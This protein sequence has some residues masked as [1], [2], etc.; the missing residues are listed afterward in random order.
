M[1]EGRPA[2]VDRRAERRALADWTKEAWSGQFR[3]VTV[4]GDAGIGKTALVD[5]LVEEWLDAGADVRS[6]V[7]HEDLEIPYLPVVTAIRRH[8]DTRVAAADAPASLLDRTPDL[9]IAITDE[10]LTAAGHGRIVL[11]IDDLHWADPAT[12][13]LL[14]HVLIAASRESLSHAL[15][16]LVVLGTRPTE[17]ER[18]AASLLERLEREGANRPLRLG[19]LDELSVNEMLESMLTAPPSRRLLDEVLDITEGNP[20]FVR[21]MIEH[22][23]EVGSLE[24]RHDEVVPL[25]E[26]VAEQVELDGVL[27]RRVD[28]LSDDGR[29]MLSL[30]AHMGHGHD[31]DELR[32]V[33]GLDEDPFDDCMD[34]LEGAGLMIERADATYAFP[35][36]LVRQLLAR[37]Q[38]RRA[39]RGVHAHIAARLID[40]SS[41]PTSE[42]EMRIAHHLRRAARR[43]PL[44]QLLHFATRATDHCVDLGAWAKAARYAD[45][46]LGALD[47]AVRT[48]GGVPTPGDPGG[49]DA[50]RTRLHLAAA[51]AN[52]RNHDASET[53][54]HCDAAIDAARASDDLDSWGRALLI[55]QR[56]RLTLTGEHGADSGA[57][58]PIAEFL[59]AAGEEVPTVRAR[60]WQLLTEI[61]VSNQDLERAST[62][63]AEALRLGREAGDDVL[64]AEL[65]FAV[66]LE[67]LGALEPDA[68]IT[69]FRAS[70]DAAARGGDPWVL[71][72][73]LGRLALCHLLRGEVDEARAVAV[74]A[75]DLDR[76]THH[77]AEHGLVTAATAILQLVEGELA[78][79]ER[80]AEDAIQL[81]ARSSFYFILLLALPCVAYARALRDDRLGAQQALEA[82]RA[83]GVRGSRQFGILVDALTVPSDEFAA[84][85]ADGYEPASQGP[86]N[87]F[88]AAGLD[89]DVEIG[90][91]LGRQDVLRPALAQ[92]EELSRRDIELLLPTGASVQRLRARSL[93]GLGRED[94]GIAVLAAAEPRLRAHGARV[95]AVRCAAERCL[96]L[97]RRDPDAASAL[98]VETALELDGLSLLGVLRDFR[99]RLPGSLSTGTRL[100]R[101]VVA[102]DIV[103]STPL[104]VE[105]GDER[106]VDLVHELNDIVRRRLAEHGGVP[107]KYTGDG[108]YAWFLEAAEALRCAVAVRRDLEHR[109]ATA[110]A[111]LVTMRTG[112]AVG[113][114]VDDA[115]DLLGLAVVTASRL[116]AVASSEEILCSAEA[117]DEAAAA[118]STRPLGAMSL[119][120]I[121]RPVDVL[122]I[123]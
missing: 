117:A 29:R 114:P 53:A 116:C 36:P 49:L 7:C 99:S 62:A 55:A 2:F 26:I 96:A 30:A 118:V 27:R 121:D 21:T 5:E 56:S 103:G 42:T 31:L 12:V 38:S 73:P 4:I 39:R 57:H 90:V 65:D 83:S 87:L 35:H 85:P 51:I 89:V 1:L 11:R 47:A 52:F 37:E 106:Y 110:P 84:A 97:A 112:I 48:D 111:A 69:S 16:L 3:I 15:T 100:R 18:P 79:A 123:A 32:H 94:E 120:G 34:E 101:T 14:R 98:A 10:L 81:H 108:V 25:G 46:A 102:W 91:R 72:W 113:Q 59:E 44:D 115:G 43:A 74:E 45:V 70:A 77:W 24:V 58:L 41:T 40:R 86:P 92:L 28:R 75:L 76:R 13:E 88:S 19:P 50:E 6:S 67:R 95:E 80:R 9:F 66:G 17:P 93:I 104:L 54:R 107:F 68:A 22:L 60:C 109:N 33:V 64:T 23:A 82:W 78:G 8:P 20:L 63:A 105:A 122:A 71:A 61:A 119:K